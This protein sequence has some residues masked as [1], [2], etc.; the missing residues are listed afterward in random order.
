MRWQD[1]RRSSNIEDQ[2]GMRPAA[3]GGVGGVGAIVI[4]LVALFFGVDPTALLQGLDN[5]T[6]QTASAPSGGGAV[7]DDQTTQ[8]V[9]AVLGSTEDTWGAVFRENGAQYTP[10]TLTLFSGAVR[11]GCGM[12]QTASGPFYCPADRKVYLDTA[13]FQELSQRFGAPGDFARAYVIAHE[14]GHHVQNLLGIMDKMA[15]ARQRGQNAN[16]LSV[17]LELQA[18]C[19]AGVWA[20]RGDQDGHFIEPGDV[21]SALRAAAAVGDDT[22]QKQSQGYVVPDSF[23][24]GSAEQRARWFHRG[25]DAGQPTACDTFSAQSL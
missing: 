12:A 18:D 8:F 23:T 5:G 20:K 4:V 7:Q 13:F 24:H 3:I 15:A 21:E 1:L 16:A 17:R 2:R 9:S 14:V 19:F 25:Y 22:L 11:S 6:T 10:P